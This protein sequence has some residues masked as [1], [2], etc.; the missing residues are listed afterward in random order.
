[1]GPGSSGLIKITLLCAQPWPLLCPLGY[2]IKVGILSH[3]FQKGK[4]KLRRSP[5]QGCQ[6]WSAWPPTHVPSCRPE[7][8]SKTA[9]T[10]PQV[11][12]RLATVWQL[13]PGTSAP[14]GQGRARKVHGSRQECPPPAFLSFSLLF[15]C[16]ARPCYL[17]LSLTPSSSCLKFRLWTFPLGAVMCLF[18]VLDSPPAPISGTLGHLDSASTPFSIS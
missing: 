18:C 5:V 2:I 1:M 7:C 3:I 6:P 8:F 13:D 15:L 10:I 12:L 4:Q 14:W 17:P 11:G 9:S 16:S